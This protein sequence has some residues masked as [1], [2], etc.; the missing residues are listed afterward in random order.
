MHAGS[1]AG[2][3]WELEMGRSFPRAAHFLYTRWFQTRGERSEPFD[4]AGRRYPYLPRHAYR[5][6]SVHSHGL[7][8]FWPAWPGT[9]HCSGPFSGLSIDVLHARKG[10]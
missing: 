4:V 5:Q 6:A 2:R 3:E 10:E 9:N 7:H 1:H 8:S